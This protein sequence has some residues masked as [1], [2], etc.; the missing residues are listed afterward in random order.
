[1]RVLLH[2][3]KDLGYSLQDLGNFTWNRWYNTQTEALAAPLNTRMEYARTIYDVVKNRKL[4]IVKAFID[5]CTYTLSEFKQ[6]F[7]EYFI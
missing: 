6:A 4:V 3:P 7:P 5:G 1:M 2:C